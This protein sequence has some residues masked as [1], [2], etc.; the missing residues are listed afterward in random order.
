MHA[1]LLW[2]F[3]F[4]MTFWSLNTSS[5]STSANNADMCMCSRVCVFKPA[6]LCVSVCGRT[7]FFV[8]V[9]PCVLLE[10]SFRPRGGVVFW[11]C[12]R[13]LSWVYVALSFCCRLLLPPCCRSRARWRFVQLAPGSCAVERQIFWR[14]KTGNAINHFN[15]MLIRDRQ[16]KF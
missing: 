6:C 12:R 9:R 16:H 3:F 4:K 1:I 14:S 13:P 8:R 10:R 11:M 2:R 7:L 15:M 5:F